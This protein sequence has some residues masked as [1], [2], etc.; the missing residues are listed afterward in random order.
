MP[1][2]VEDTS[3]PPAQLS[4]YIVDVLSRTG[5]ESQ[6]VKANTTPMVGY[7]KKARLRLYENNIGVAQSPAPTPVPGLVEFIPEAL[8]EPAPEFNRPI[9][10]G[11]VEFNMV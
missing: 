7:I 6:V 3:S 2:L 10:V 8:K 11:D 4:S 9:Q 1:V 5:V